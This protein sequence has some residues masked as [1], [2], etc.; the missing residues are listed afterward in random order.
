MPEP[1]SPLLRRRVLLSHDLRTSSESDLFNMKKKKDAKLNSMKEYA[2]RTHP[3]SFDNDS[4]YRKSL[5]QDQA[6]E[7]LLLDFDRLGNNDRESPTTDSDINRSKEEEE[8]VKETRPSKPILYRA[9]HSSFDEGLSSLPERNPSRQLGPLA[10]TYANS[11]VLQ[12][13]SQ[14]KPNCK[15]S[16]NGHA[17]S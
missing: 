11:P 8:E 10:K 13:K 12:R 1:K 7:K 16:S 4:S 2:K 3:D 9:S 14:Q 17:N 6:Y 15:S 5:E